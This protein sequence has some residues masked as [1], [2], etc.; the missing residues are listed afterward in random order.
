MTADD[1]YSSRNRKDLPQQIQL[2]LSKNENTFFS[3]F[4]SYLKRTWNVEDFEKKDNP[5]SLC[6]FEIEDGEKCC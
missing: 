4:A 5:H 2:Q 6:A 3:I 1:K